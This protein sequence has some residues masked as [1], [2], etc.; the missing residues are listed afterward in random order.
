MVF[1]SAQSLHNAI[2]ATNAIIWEVVQNGDVVAVLRQLCDG[3]LVSSS[4][5]YQNHSLIKKSLRF[6]AVII[7]PSS[8]KAFPN[9]TS[10]STV[11]GSG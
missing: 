2:K 10:C 6:S 5:H 4:F 8:L 3:V 11:A 7:L 1:T 9:G